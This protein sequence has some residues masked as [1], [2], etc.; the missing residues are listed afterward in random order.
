VRLTRIA[1]AFGRRWSAFSDFFQGLRHWQRRETD[2]AIA[3]LKRASEKSPAMPQAQYVLALAYNF[4]DEPQTARKH[5]D[6][7]IPYLEGLTDAMQ[8]RLLALRARLTFDFAKESEYLSRLQERF[9]YSKEVHFELA[10]TYFHRGQARDAI[11]EYQSALKID[12]NFSQALNHMGYCYSYLGDHHQAISLFEAYRNL[13]QSANSFDSLGDGYFY[14]GDL[15]LAESNKIT[16][17]ASAPGM[18]WACLTLADIYTLRAEFAKA[19]NALQRYQKLR[20]GAQGAYQA[21][22]K[23]AFILLLEN[24]PPG[25]LAAVN[26]ALRLF[27]STEIM[28][29]SAE[30]HWLRGLILLAGDRAAEA[31]VE[32]EWLLNLCEQYRLGERNFLAPLKF[33]LHLSALLA[34]HDAMP[35]K[36]DQ[37]F[38]KLLSMKTQLSY[39]ITCY[40]YPF[41]LTEYG[42][43]LFRQKRTVA[44]LSQAD[45]ALAFTAKYPPALWLKIDVWRGQNKP[46]WRALAQVIAEVYGPGEERNSRRKRLTDL[47][48]ASSSR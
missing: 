2:E 9:P 36:A 16:A 48:R 29:N 1:S 14:A 45:A 19:V 17:L 32:W 12:R 27:D 5:V 47:L 10:E 3:A 28:N 23:R 46:E 33:Y 38:K 22:C 21:F 44:A 26:E 35:E 20:P 8:L 25:A 11:R 31:K 13:D 41:F 15:I 6:A 42:H 24:D 40:N 4:M 43:F 37:L 39:W 18:F 30:A 34:E 7:V